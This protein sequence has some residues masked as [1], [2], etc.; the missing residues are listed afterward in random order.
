MKI[1]LPTNG[2]EVDSHFGHC[3]YFMVFT[4]NDK[5]EI[6]S[7]ELIKSPAGC[8]CKSNIVQTLSQLG[9]SIMLAGNMGEGAVNVLNS[10][11]IEVVRGCA[12]EVKTVAR[13]WL[14]GDIGDSGTACHEHQN[15]CHNDS[16]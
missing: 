5:K 3:E 12:G 14:D 16:H 10:H 13:K 7:E 6:V 9:V 15:G 11:G 1:A 4:T 8:G 2:N